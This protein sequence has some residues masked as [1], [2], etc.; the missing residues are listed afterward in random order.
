MVVNGVKGEGEVNLPVR[1]P[2]R[3]VLSRG[4]IGPKGKA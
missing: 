1:L 3:G 4:F 2:I